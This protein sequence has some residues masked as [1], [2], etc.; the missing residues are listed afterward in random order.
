REGGDDPAE[1]VYLYREFVS[2]AVRVL[3]PTGTFAGSED[4]LHSFIA[5]LQLGLKERFG[6]VDHLRTAVQEEPVTGATYRKQY[7]L[8][9]DTVPGGTGYL[10]QLMRETEPM[11]DV[12]ERALAVL[13]GCPCNRD[14]DKDG[15]YRCLYAYRT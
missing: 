5:A 1:H 7:L 3:L 8:L 15:C 9:Y 2:E 13:T 10:G 11:M 12:F 6:R 4:K 14:P